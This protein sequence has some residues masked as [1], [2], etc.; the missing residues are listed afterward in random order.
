MK[1]YTRDWLDSKELRRCSFLARA[2]LLDLMCLAHEGVPY[3]NL[4]DKIGPLTFDYMASRCVV[5]SKQFHAAIA[6]LKE[7]GRI[8]SEDGILLFIPRMVS[9]ESVRVRRATG[10]SAS[11]GHPKTHP[12]KH[13]EGYPSEEDHG[14]P[15][16]EI[17]SRARMRA[18]SD[19][20]SDSEFVCF[21]KTWER[22]LKTWLEPCACGLRFPAR[23]VDL[24]AQMWPSL[25]KRQV[26][27]T[28]TIDSVIEG[29]IRYR[30]S[31]DW[32]KDGGKYVCNL[33][34][35][36]G[37]SKNG[38]PSAPK[39]NDQ[40]PRFSCRISAVQESRDP[41]EELQQSIT[42]LEASV[43]EEQDP[44]YR[45]IAQDVLAENRSRLTD[46]MRSEAK[47]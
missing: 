17:D 8:G 1:L 37:F 30:S 5:T 2:V 10:G 6:E 35:F 21:E 22:F 23:D 7:K 20:D 13:K 46:L 41:V 38:M 34:T 24:A 45:Q 16:F 4:S 3:G 19:S 31:A 12:P 26:I 27:T 36:L 40:P 33:S 43:R 44:K 47:H 32:H 18:D 15:S 39:W 14:H 29:L 42:E 28:E 9:D 25:W 11:I